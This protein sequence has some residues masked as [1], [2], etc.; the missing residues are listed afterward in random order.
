MNFNLHSDVKEA[1]IITIT[2]LRGSLLPYVKHHPMGD[3]SLLA[4]EF[5]A[6]RGDKLGV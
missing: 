2:M 4:K 6:G 3:V 1:S 5:F